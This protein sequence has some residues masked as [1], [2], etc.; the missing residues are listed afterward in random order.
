MAETLTLK[1]R[2]ITWLSSLSMPDPK[3]TTLEKSRAWMSQSSKGPSFLVGTHKELASVRDEQIAGVKVRRYVPEGAKPGVVVYFHGGGFV[4]GDLD[5]HESPSRGLA[6]ATGREVVAVDYRL[7]P[8]HRY[9]AAVDD[10]MAVTKAL[11]AQH[12]VVVC[13]D[14]AGGNLAAVVANRCAA[15][16]VSLVAQVLVYPMADG[17]TPRESHSQFATGF[18]LTHASVRVFLDTYVPELPRR[19]EPDCSPFHATSLRGVVP[20]YVLLAGCD[21][22][23]DEGRAY[24]N[25]LQ[26]DGVETVLD[27]VPGVI[28]GFFSLQG[29]SEGKAATKRVARWLAPRW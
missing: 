25:K 3:N 16:G 17:V 12:R 6:N 29:L 4:L 27:E 15:E 1:W 14:S 23:R 24:A 2:T 8:E 18:F 19:S 13:G 28:H 21:V 7:A 20:G 5:S 11:A 22:L 26:S 10:C 9:P